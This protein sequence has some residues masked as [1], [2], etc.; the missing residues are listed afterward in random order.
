MTNYTKKAVKGAS[1]VFIISLISAFMG[2]VVRSLLARNITVEEF[3]LFYSV[4][5]FFGLIGIFK[6]L[7]LD[8]ALIK[9]IPE[10]LHKNKNNSIKSSLVFVLFIQILMN[11]VIIFLIFILSD[12]LSINFFH[13]TSA[14]YVLKLMAIAIFIDSFVITLRYVIQGF[15]RMLYYSS[16]DLIRMF[17][18]TIIIY[19]G[20]KMNYGFSSALY[21]YILTPIIL[22]LIFIPIFIKKIFPK[23]I[24]SSIRIDKKLYKK[25][26]RFGLFTIATTVGGLI[27]GYTDTIVLTFF[28]GLKEVGIYNV[29]LPT[30]NI[31]I[32]FPRAIVA[33]LFPMSSELWAKNEKKLLREGMETLYKYSLIIILP[34]VLIMIS[35][36][37]FIISLLWGSKF[38]PATGALQILSLGMIFAI[39]FVI[40][41]S[42]FSG[43]GKPEINTKIFFI[44]AIFNLIFNLIL[45]PIIGIIGAAITT[46]AGYFI[47][48]I[49]GLIQIKK[50]IKIRIPYSLWARTIFSG[51]VFYGSMQI[52]KSIISIN[53]IAEFF[54][55]ILISIIIYSILL[56]LLKIVKVDEIKGIMR[57]I[58]G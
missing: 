2:Y 31:L 25:L 40:N 29:A 32:Y 48:V 53:A 49:L 11:A 17:L 1:I 41:L 50:F 42:F 16:V 33:V 14:S 4:F 47:M 23:I 5:A 51:S 28:I 12:Y 30:A 7:G 20:L 46:A 43:I 57:K 24:D 22:L 56:F 15:Q 45:I 26:L 9:F 21:A 44:G 58:I 37:K 10:F 8:T 13:D 3:G 19:I 18:L 39:I 54:V 36:S 27:L 38:D 52:L 55:I 35:F 6:T 34:S